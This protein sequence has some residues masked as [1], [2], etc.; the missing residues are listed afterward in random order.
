MLTAA[1]AYPGGFQNGMGQYLIDRFAK[2][3]LVIVVPNGP[4]RRIIGPREKLI[5]AERIA[6]ESMPEW[7]PDDAL[8]MVKRRGLE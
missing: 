8:R 5:E 6:R 7:A 1:E 4:D 3:I 2:S